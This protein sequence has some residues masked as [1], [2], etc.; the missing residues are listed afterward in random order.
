MKNFK[1]EANEL[2]QRNE[3]KSVFGGRAQECRL[4]VTWSHSGSTETL[5]G[6]H[7][8]SGQSGSQEANQDCVDGISS[9]V[10][11]SCSYDCE[12]DGWGQ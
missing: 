11:S 9:G 4:T 5:S 8:S 1:V 3:L 12:Y 7:Y 10:V 6:S 2:L